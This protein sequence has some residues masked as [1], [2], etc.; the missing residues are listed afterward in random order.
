MDICKIIVGK[1]IYNIFLPKNFSQFTN[2]L[3]IGFIIFIYFI[4]I[5]KNNYLFYSNFNVFYLNQLFFGQPSSRF[6][7][8]IY[9]WMILLMCS[10]KDMNISSKVK[11]FFIPSL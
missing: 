2:A 9:I 4:F 8:E 11:L 6:F 1:A 3:G 7:F 10:F 5:K